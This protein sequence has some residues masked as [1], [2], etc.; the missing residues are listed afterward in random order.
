[1]IAKI[2]IVD[3]EPDFLELLEM[4]LGSH[5]YLIRTV[6]NA[7]EA[8]SAIRRDRPDMV[9]LDIILPDMSGVE[10]A[11]KLKNTPETADIP[12]I[13][14]TAKD[15]ETDIVV[16]L[17]VGA[18]DYV[19]KPFSTSVLVARIEAVLRRAVPSGKVSEDVLSVGPVKILIKSH[20]VLVDSKPTE[21]TLAEYQILLALFEANEAVLSRT[22]LKAQL[23]D[24]GPEVAERVV[25][26][27]VASLRKKLGEAKKIIK[28]VHRMGYRV[29]K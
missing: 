13:L 11:A 16:G 20:Q 18:D 17:S 9:L 8:V 10:L 12:V 28:T 1:M 3:D 19:T 24:S 25:D 23:V 6:T 15:K 5:G 7:A 2:L 4:N 14:V 22:D 21:L 29:S 27:H 26:V